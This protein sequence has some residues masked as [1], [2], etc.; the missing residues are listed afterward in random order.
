MSGGL[1]RSRTPRRPSGAR[2]Q[3]CGAVLRQ[4]PADQLVAGTVAGPLFCSR[5]DQFD[6]TLV[7]TDDHLAPALEYGPPA[8]RF[9]GCC[10]A[11][12][13]PPT[14]RLV[15]WTPCLWTGNG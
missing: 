9:P 2:C 12:P 14:W 7:K 1:R 15:R 8:H 3:Q 4:Y 10:P 6:Q 5:G 13:F 11:A